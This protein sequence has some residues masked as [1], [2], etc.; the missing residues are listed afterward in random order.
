MD[1]FQPQ[2]R[3]FALLVPLVI[4]AESVLVFQ[5]YVLQGATHLRVLAAVSHAPLVIFVLMVS[6]HLAWPV[7]TKPQWVKVCA[8]NVLLAPL[9]R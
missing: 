7:L 2:E 8:L 1:H 4:S 6:K 5:L 9:V 3:V